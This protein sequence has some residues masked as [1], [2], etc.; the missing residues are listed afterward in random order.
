MSTLDDKPSNPGWFTRIGHPGYF[1]SWTRFLVIPMWVLTIIAFA[2][3]LYFSFLGSPGD[4]Q[5]GDTVR[6]M[7]VHVPSSW[8][9]Q[10][11]YAVM[12]CSA[13]GTLVWRHPM[14]DVSQKAA[15]P[16][17]VLFTTLSLMTGS[18][19]GR[20]TWGT[21]WEWDGRMTSTL[22]LLLIYLGIMA[23]WRAFDDQL[24]GARIISIVTLVGSI[25][26]PII[27][28]SVDWWQTLHQP[29]SVIKADG[30]SVDGSILTPLLIM[31]LAFTLLFST[32]QLVRM[33]TEVR[34]RRV[35]SLQRAQV[36][37]AQA[38]LNEG[39]AI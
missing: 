11:C 27:K 23:M 15:V 24:K 17:G 26:I 12:F 32:L 22:I 37:N 13:I 19:W 30:P 7:Y 10:F 31:F 16:L 29:A 34:K 9:S 28:F 25:N 6:I 33:R 38:T 4:Y 39:S 36:R 1:M 3:G 8:L 35:A 2:F 18:L 5:M 14:A 21:Y 20:P